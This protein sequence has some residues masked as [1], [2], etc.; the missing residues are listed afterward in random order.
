MGPL[1][2]KARSS[3][4]LRPQAPAHGSAP[5]LPA[6]TPAWHRM[7]QEAGAFA[8]ARCVGGCLAAASPPLSF[9]RKP[10]PRVPLRS[11][12]IWSCMWRW[13]LFLA[14][15]CL[16]CR[17]NDLMKILNALKAW[18]WEG[19]TGSRSRRR[20]RRLRQRPCRGAAPPVPAAGT[21]S[22]LFLH[23]S[24]SASRSRGRGTP[25]IADEETEAQGL[26]QVAQ[27]H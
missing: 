7:P 8:G 1:S 19:R 23:R 2:L 25:R 24:A 17:K 20:P 14:F 22:G 4:W 11:L 6:R 13:E 21:R 9:P 27:G 26:N 16:R 5:R 15:P 10:A 3:F 18:G 12:R